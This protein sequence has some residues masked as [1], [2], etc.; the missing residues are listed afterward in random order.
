MISRMAL[1]VNGVIVAATGVATAAATFGAWRA[2]S[3][4]SKA[5]HKTV[6]IAEAA[7]R[8]RRWTALT[9]QFRY[10]TEGSGTGIPA[11]E[12]EYPPRRSHGAGT[13]RPRHRHNPR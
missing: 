13:A 1:D 2:A 5:A 11:R 3:S 7:E 12:A 10:E 8:D 4:A 6:E 9:P